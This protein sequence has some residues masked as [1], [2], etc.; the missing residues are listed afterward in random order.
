VEVIVPLV[1]KD[2]LEGGKLVDMEAGLQKVR[3]RCGQIV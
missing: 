3:E 2:G 1:P